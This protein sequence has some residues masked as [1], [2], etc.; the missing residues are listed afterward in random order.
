MRLW[1]RGAGVADVRGKAD[2]A[3]SSNDALVRRL[4]SLVV[5]FSNASTPLSSEDIRSEYYPDVSVDTIQKQFRRDR[6]RLERCGL[7]SAN[8]SHLPSAVV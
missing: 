2:G 8:G 5:A 7:T 6:E 3:A 4:V 1:K